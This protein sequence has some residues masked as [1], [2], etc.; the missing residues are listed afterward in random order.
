VSGG[1]RRETAAPEP[2]G[3]DWS[4]ETAPVESP[5]SHRPDRY[6]EVGPVAV[7]GSTEVV[8]CVDQR[9][10]RRVA[11][12]AARRDVEVDPD[13]ESMLDRE[14]RITG[15]LEHPN[16]IPV[17]DAGED[18][19]GGAFYVMRLVSHPSLAVVL[20]RLAA[21]NLAALA[22]YR[23]GRRLRDFLQICHAV[24]YAHSRGVVHCDLKPANVLLGNFGEVWVVDWG[25]AFDQS[26][27]TGLRG[28]TPGYMAPEQLDPRCDFVDAT[29]DVFALGALLY[30]MVALRPAFDGATADD[31]SAALRDYAAGRAP[32]APPS[33]HSAAGAIA[34]PA[35]AALDAI[36][37]RALQAARV[38]RYP[39]AAELARAIEDL[40]DAP[41]G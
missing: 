18:I 29:T 6:R 12:K 28:G 9:L 7:G 10:G 38:D 20:A 31:V 27:R 36:C 33:S 16:I 35:A 4:D 11:I 13:M 22:S 41:L 32:L 17:Y 25:F 34:T 30:E 3:E 15:C 40:L 26:A 14:A 39:S 19:R 21:G 2:I 5:G 23:L 1:R 8:E 24:D 37:A